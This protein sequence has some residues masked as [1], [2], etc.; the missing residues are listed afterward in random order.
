MI[1]LSLAS[2]SSS[3]EVG[4]LVSTGSSGASLLGLRPGLRA[5]GRAGGRA[6]GRPGLRTGVAVRLLEGPGC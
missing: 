1:G 5:R 2:P 4:G 3:S 6:G